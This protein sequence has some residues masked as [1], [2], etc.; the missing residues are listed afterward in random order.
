MHR[1]EIGAAFMPRH[2]FRETARV[3]INFTEVN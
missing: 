2:F 3:A 1:D